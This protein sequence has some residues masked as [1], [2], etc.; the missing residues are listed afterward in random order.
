MTPT[1]TYIPWLTLLIVLPLAGTLIC[2]IFRR[3]PSACRWWTL[4]STL[5]VLRITS[6][7]VC[8]TK[9][10]RCGDYPD[11][12]RAEAALS[13]LETLIVLDALPTATVHRADLFLPTTT[14]AE[15]DS[16]NFV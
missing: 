3:L 1:S 16:Y 10:L 8:Y 4:I 15:Q 7:N 6:Y 12:G 14:V 13:R 2:L 9:L 11:P 5:V